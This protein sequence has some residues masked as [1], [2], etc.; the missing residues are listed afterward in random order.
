MDDLDR[1]IL[2][3]QTLRTIINKQDRQIKDAEEIMEQMVQGIE[4]LNGL[5]ENYAFA[6]ADIALVDYKNYKE[7]W[8]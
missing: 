6:P 3:I 4:G 5:A 1:N 7:K 8:K 2:K